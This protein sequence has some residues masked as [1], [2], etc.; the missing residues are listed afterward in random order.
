MDDLGRICAGGIKRP[1]RDEFACNRARF[2]PQFAQRGLVRVFSDVVKLPGRDLRQDFA[3]G[4]AELPLEQ[5]VAIFQQRQ[6]AHSAVVDGIF[7]R[8]G[9]AVRQA[10]GVLIDMQHI[11]VENRLG[12]EF[13]F[14]QIFKFFHCF[15]ASFV[16][17]YLTVLRL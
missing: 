2:L 4:V 3:H 7:P 12:R 8:G 14:L 15:S 10:D 5:H 1:E 16:F 6:D 17:S 11:A 9:L 13:C